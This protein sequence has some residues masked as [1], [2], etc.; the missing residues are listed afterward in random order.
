ML[1]SQPGERGTAL[2]VRDRR[3]HQLGERGQPYLSVRRQGLL[4]RPRADDHDAPQ[5]ALD[6]DR[7]PDRPADPVLADV[8]TDRTGGIDIAVDPRRVA[9]FEHNRSDV[10]ATQAPPAA[11][12]KDSRWR[13]P[14]GDEGDRA[15][16]LVA[17]QVGLSG[18]QHP[19]GLPGDCREHLLRRHPTRHQ[20][21]DPPQRRLL[22]GKLTQPCLIG[23]ITAH[24]PVGGMA[25][26]GAGIWRVHTT[27]GSLVP[28]GR[29]RLRRSLRPPQP[30]RETQVRAGAVHPLANTRDAWS[31]S[32]ARLLFP[33]VLAA[34]HLCECI[35]ASP[36][37]RQPGLVLASSAPAGPRS[38]AR[39]PL[40]CDNCA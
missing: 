19:P 32:P 23:R 28:G 35:A 7:C 12:G 24:P 22:V 5:A 16:G 14:G 8:G 38:P 39:A 4:P 6:G 11:N 3:R 26:T 33:Q 9:R 36:V 34:Q 31:A 13:A 27:D 17:A 29:Q 2:G 21:R 25:R 20:R 18:G 30:I 1:L 10:I 40:T 15:V 37:V